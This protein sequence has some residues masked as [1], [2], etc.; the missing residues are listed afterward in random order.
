MHSDPHC[1]AMRPTETSFPRVYEIHK[2][3]SGK[4]SKN[5]YEVGLG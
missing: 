3:K 4:P 2:T 5:T 1:E